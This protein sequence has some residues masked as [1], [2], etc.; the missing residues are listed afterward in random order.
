ME[1]ETVKETKCKETP[2]TVNELSDSDKLKSEGSGTK[3]QESKVPARSWT[4][5]IWGDNKSDSVKKVIKNES[6]PEEKAKSESE[7]ASSDSTPSASSRS[8][9][10]EP[11]GKTSLT[12]IVGVI[13]KNGSE[14]GNT[15]NRKSSRK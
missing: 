5:V 2:T 3:V 10:P 12:P 4:S 1:I 11:G 13:Q 15:P 9:S 6:E 7:I 8:I 14:S